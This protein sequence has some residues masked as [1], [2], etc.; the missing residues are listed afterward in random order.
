VKPLN[1]PPTIALDQSRLY[2]PGL[3]IV[4]AGRAGCG[5]WERPVGLRGTLVEVLLPVVDAE[6]VEVTGELL[7][8]ELDAWL[9]IVNSR[10]LTRPGLSRVAAGALGLS[11]R[12]MWWVRRPPSP[13]PTIDTLQA[14]KIWRALRRE[15]I[16]VARCTV[17]RLMVELGIAGVVRGK[18]RRT[19]RTDEGTA[20]PAG[21]VDRQFSAT[22]P[23]QL[24]V[25]DITYLRTW[26][27]FAHAA[28]SS[29]SIPA[30]SSAGRSPTICAP[31]WPSTPSSRRSGLATNASTDS[32][33]TPTGEPIPLDPLQRTARRRRRGRFG[34]LAR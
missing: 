3:G 33:T 24:W 2:R 21:L 20:L 5:P 11:R 32:C 12:L 30:G 31:S 7:L 26:S 29:T 15:G 34:R 28:L 14:R 17:E 16:T 27:G 4:G 19:T 10:S 6:R 8:G 25:A 18:P 22:R 23:N 9:R 1:G 13:G